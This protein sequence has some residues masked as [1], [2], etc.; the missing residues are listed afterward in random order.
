MGVKS[1][2]HCCPVEVVSISLQGPPPN[3][4]TLEGQFPVARV[5]RI[6]VASREVKLLGLERDRG[7]FRQKNEFAAL[8]LWDLPIG[9]SCYCAM[10]ST[11]LVASYH[12]IEVHGRT[13]WLQ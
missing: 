1:D 5:Y 3:C 7:A 4:Q 6:R 10:K 8:L 2:P 13:T 12:P 9:H 11:Q